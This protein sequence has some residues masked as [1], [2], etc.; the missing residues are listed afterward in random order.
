MADSAIRNDFSRAMFLYKDFITQAAA[1]TNPPT[2]LIAGIHQDD[3]GAPCGRK[4]DRSGRTPPELCEDRFY[5][6][7]EY[8]SLTPGN[9]VF[10]KNQRDKR[11]GGGGGG[12]GC[13]SST[14][15]NKE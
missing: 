11:N 6:R 1:S 8:M 4:R 12:C 2:F 15:M 7:E 13:G 10:L 9:R 14:Q 3:K 5:K